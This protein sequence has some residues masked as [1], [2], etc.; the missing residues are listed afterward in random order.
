MKKFFLFCA[1]AVALILC[2]CSKSDYRTALPA[3]ASIVFSVNNDALATKANVGDFTQSPLYKVIE[4]GMS[5][6]GL[7]ADDQAY[8]LSLAAHPGQMGIDTAAD[9][10]GFM[11]DLDSRMNPRAGIV[12]KVGNRGDLDK[13]VEW[14]EKQADG[15]MAVV[16]EEKITFL[17][18]TDSGDAPV[19]AYTDDTFLFYYSPDMNAEETKAEAKKLFAQKQ[20]ESL[21]GVAHM[22]DF[23]RG[24][25][26]MQVMV[27]YGS[28]MAAMQEQAAMQMT[29]M[30]FMSKMVLFM[31]T[32]HEQGQVV[33]DARIAFTD[34]QA[35]QQFAELAAMSGK[36]KGDFLKMLPDQN[37]GIMAA[38]LKGAKMYEIFEKMPMVAMVL[39]MAP[40]AKSIVSALDGDFALAFHGATANAAYLTFIAEVNDPAVL[41]KIKALIPSEA[42]MVPDGNNA[43]I[44]LGNGLM[45]HFGVIGNTLYATTFEGALPYLSGAEGSAY[46]GRMSTLFGDTHQ[47]FHVDFALVRELLDKLVAD[48]AIDRQ[49]AMAFPILDL[50]ESIEVTAPDPMNAKMVL[51]MTDKER[52]AA[53][54]FYKTIESYAPM[55]MGGM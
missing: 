10:Y 14:I 5:H 48:G 54:T 24:G 4:Q 11:T 30:E 12:A 9:L 32:N 2:S 25:N 6:S 26:D 19:L 1:T 7:S 13:F 51:R 16:E 20:E 18:S 17:A 52:N 27:S 28:M 37:I 39:A 50:F 42:N 55:M 36:I 40:E 23:F 35:E 45:L 49:V 46:A 31:T 47:V 8:V 3:D 29:G 15:E 34:E 41:E 43:K 22:A 38:N 53:E 21:V 44:D 33:T